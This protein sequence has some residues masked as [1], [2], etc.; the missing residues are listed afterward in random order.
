MINVFT[1]TYN[2]AHLLARLYESLCK[3]TF[4]YFEWIIVDDGSTDKTKVVV[5]GFVAEDKINIRYFRQENGGKHRAINQ[6]VKE[7][8]GELFFIV[9]SDDWL[10][11]N[12]LAIV[13]EQWQIVKDNPKVGGVC[14]LDMTQNGKVIGSGLPCDHLVCS[15]MDI[16]LKHYVTGDLKEV[17]R[18][19]V[20]REMPFPEYEGEKFCPEALAWN[21]LA[22][23]Y[24][25]LFFNK[26]IY[27][28]EYQP[29]GLTANIVRV[30]MQSPIASTT[31]YQELLTHDIPLKQKVKAAIN[32]WRFAACLPAGTTA[33]H[34]PW[35][36]RICQPIGLLMHRHDLQLLAH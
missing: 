6:G 24:D 30:R 29:G 32:Y 15:S 9:D 8:R 2:R 22:Q 18:T 20:L 27:I 35:Y 11:E 34:L 36:W 3:Q 10:P 5:D 26:P 7:A 21:R 1:P 12:A 25:L 13:Y 23:K 17:F 28:A 19:S 31:C 14:G 16:R 4:K 33:P